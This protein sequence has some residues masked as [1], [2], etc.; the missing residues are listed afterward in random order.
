[1]T[2]HDARKPV[3]VGVSRSVAARSALDWA[4]DAA[5]RRGLP[6]HL[7][8]AQEWPTGAAPKDLHDSREHL[9]ATHFRATGQTLL[10]SHR[11]WAED[12]RTGLEITVEVVDGRPAHVLREAAEHA[13]L[14][15]VGAHRASG[16]GEAFT[17]GGVGP[18]LVGHPPCPVALVFEPERGGEESGPV[19]VGADGSVASAPAVAFAFEEAALCGV[20]LRAVLV[21]RPSRG[22]WPEDNGDPLSEASGL[23]FGRGEKYPEVQVQREVLIGRPPGKLAGA[24]AGAHCLVVGSRGHGGFRGMVLGSVSRTLVHLAPCPLVV[25]PGEPA[26]H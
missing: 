23:L 20:P 17:F 21:R 16:P 12:R 1:M 2:S 14:L 10:D 26:T 13:A 25:V 11:G 3:V 4:A 5:A 7:I 19:V 24:A 15:V 9:W 6:L 18:S 22:D 8:H